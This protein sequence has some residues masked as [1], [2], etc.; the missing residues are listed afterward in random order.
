MGE[1][2]EGLAHMFAQPEPAEVFADLIEGLLDGLPKKNGW[3]M[4]ARAGHAGPERIQKFLNAASWDDAALVGAVRD[5]ALARLGDEAAV[6]VVDDIQSIK[7]GDKSVGVAFRH[8]GTTGDVSNCQVMVMLTYAAPVGHTFL[9]RRLYLPESR[10]HDA[11]RR[12]EAGV[13]AEAGFLTKPRLAALMLA[14]ALAAGVPFR[15]F[16]SDSDEDSTFPGD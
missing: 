4:S 13:P 5:Y 12:K 2:T 16:A 6:L 8:C 11:E 7:K 3:T 15:W 9:D 14:D 10:A 1:L